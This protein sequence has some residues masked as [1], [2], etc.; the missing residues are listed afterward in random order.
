MLCTAIVPLGDRGTPLDEDHPAHWTSRKCSTQRRP[1]ET[2]G[3]RWAA[4]K[5]WH[6]TGQVPVNN[7]AIVNGNSGNCLLINGSHYMVVGVCW[8]TVNA[9]NGGIWECLMLGI[10]MIKNGH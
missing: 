2:C 5:G 8:L 3:P 7:P 9:V 6:E 10:I 1:R 4:S